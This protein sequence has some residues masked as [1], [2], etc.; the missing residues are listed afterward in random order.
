LTEML[1][2]PDHPI[3]RHL[4]PLNPLTTQPVARVDAV[5]AAYREATGAE[6]DN[7][8]SP[9]QQRAIRD[10]LIEQDHSMPIN[11]DGMSVA[12]LGG[13]KTPFY[14]PRVHEDLAR[15]TAWLNQAPCIT[16][17]RADVT[18][19]WSSLPIRT[20]PFTAQVNTPQARARF[21]RIKELIRERIASREIDILEWVGYEMCVSVVA[22]VPESSKRIDVDN[23]VKGLLDAMKG[24]IYD[25]DRLVQHLSSRRVVH[26]GDPEDAY[27]LV[28]LMPVI[29][30]RAD[31][32]ET[33]LHHGWGGQ[34]EI[35]AD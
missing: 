15:K 25:D 17:L 22:V 29:D 35:T 26:D 4:W 34:A 9:E 13:V 23:A 19:A 1:D 10:W 8:P 18:P 31:V 5:V 6:V 2:V 11:A 24:P 21:Q 16:C 3:V 32:V 27:Y 30:A 33:T 7:P 28:R 12:L 14:I 20:R